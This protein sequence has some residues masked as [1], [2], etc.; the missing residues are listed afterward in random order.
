MF[1]KY[2]TYQRPKKRSL[3][4]KKKSLLEKKRSLLR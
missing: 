3:S 2:Y 1:F 4:K